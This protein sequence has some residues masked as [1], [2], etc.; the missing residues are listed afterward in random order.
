MGEGLIS[1]ATQSRRLPKVADLVQ[2]VEERN[3]RVSGDLETCVK[4]LALQRYALRGSR[5]FSEE[6]LHRWAAEIHKAEVQAV[7]ELGALT[8]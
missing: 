4:E 7:A 1:L 5:V 8:L 2:E 6:D 3:E